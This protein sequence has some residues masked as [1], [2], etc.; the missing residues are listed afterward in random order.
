MT[1]TASQLRDG[2]EKT[3]LLRPEIGDKF[4]FTKQEVVDGCYAPVMK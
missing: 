4:D 2:Y 1:Q 3:S